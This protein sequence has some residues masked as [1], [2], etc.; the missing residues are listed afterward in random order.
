MTCHTCFRSNETRNKYLIFD[1][2][3]SLRTVSLKYLVYSYCPKINTNNI[4]DEYEKVSDHR[5]LLLDAVKA[6]GRKTVM[7]ETVDGLGRRVYYRSPYSCQV[8]DNFGS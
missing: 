7:T 3:K 4:L 1:G 5:T 6:D 8:Y 2:P